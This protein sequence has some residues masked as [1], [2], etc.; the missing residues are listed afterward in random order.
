MPI[1]EPEV[2]IHCLEKARAEEL[3][4][5]AILLKEGPRNGGHIG[6]WEPKAVRNSSE[7]EFAAS[8]SDPLGEECRHR[9]GSG[10]R[11]V[12]RRER[13]AAHHGGGVSALGNTRG[14]A[15]MVD[16]SSPRLPPR[17]HPGITQEVAPDEN[18]RRPK[19]T[20]REAIIY[21]VLF[22]AG[23]LKPRFEKGS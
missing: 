2:D 20:A 9:P 15:E 18:R 10:A 16:D 1:V 14:S 23:W 21:D 5:A 11:D 4:K 7:K 3:L 17:L 8:R 19:P 13:E 22:V 12:Y 6:V